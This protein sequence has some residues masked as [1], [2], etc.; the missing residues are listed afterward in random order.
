MC[1]CCQMKIFHSSSL[2]SCSW[3]PGRKIYIDSHSGIWNLSF[4]N[5][6]SQVWSN[7]IKPEEIESSSDRGTLTS[8]FSRTFFSAERIIIFGAKDYHCKM[9]QFSRIRTGFLVLSVT[10][11]VRQCA[12]RAFSTL[13]NTL[14]FSNFPTKLFLSVDFSSQQNALMSVNCFLHNLVEWTKKFCC[15]SKTLPLDS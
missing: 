13:A 6:C 2:T 3:F 8:H 15:F 1:Y 5:P 4:W 14:A 9:V 10:Q 12:R 11:L 7:H